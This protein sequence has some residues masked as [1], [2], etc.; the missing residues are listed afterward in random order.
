LLCRFLD[1]QAFQSI[2]TSYFYL[3]IN[4]AVF[5]IIAGIILLFLQYLVLKYKKTVLKTTEKEESEALLAL[6][7]KLKN[8]RGNYQA[9][10]EQSFDAIYVLDY[11]GKFI[12]ANSRLCKMTGYTRDELLTRNITDLID[13]GQLKTDPFVPYNSKYDEGIIKERRLIRKNGEVFDVEISAKKLTENRLLVIAEDIT[14]RKQLEI[15]LHEAE[16]KFH[17]LAE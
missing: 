7:E 9:L 16:L 4:P 12:D 17:P 6:T 15:E 11:S 1:I 8:C 5:L 14:R 10:I 3:K 13:P 2:S